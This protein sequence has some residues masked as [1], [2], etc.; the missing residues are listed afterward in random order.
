MGQRSDELLAHAR[1]A[2]PLVA[3]RG[4]EALLLA[5]ASGCRVYDSD[6]VAYVDVLG[7]GGTCL[8][9]YANQYLLDAGRRAS[10]L[11]LAAGF[12]AAVEIELLELFEELLPQFGPW[13]VAGSEVEAW[14]LALRWCR[15][16]TGRQRLVVF[17]GN[18]RGALESA[19]VTPAGPL[20][21]SQPLL[22][23]I[24]P[25]IARLVRI[26]PWGDLEAFDQVMTDVGFDAAAVVV[27]PIQSL[28]GVVL[29]D[30]AFLRAVAERT[31]NIGARLVLDETLTGF[32]LAR[33]GAAELFNVAPDV[34]VYGGILG[35]GLSQIG[36]VTWARQLEAQPGDDLVAPPPPAAVLAATATLSV[37][38]NDAIHLRL[39][40]RGAQLQTGVEALAERFSRHL[41][42]SRVG[43]IF[44]CAFSRSPVRDG[45][46]F[47]R[48]DQESWSRFVRHCREAG[49]LLP[50]RSPVSSFL[51]HAHGVKDIDAILTAMETALRKMQKEDE[52]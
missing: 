10:T 37:L 28:F 12:H 11:G 20:G 3:R 4:S 15:R 7:G 22:A 52:V 44:A 14:E 39:E 32:R 1:S 33:G 18:R 38:R 40:E 17:D 8:L 46:S 34:A 26:V 50:A 2:A 27:D 5:K 43:S 30:E 45:M 35:G 19:Q 13:V 49:V 24:P 6:N 21:M 36:A 23:G 51:S 42:C 31:R 16:D 25:E 9:G 29:P 47:A 41:L 48:V